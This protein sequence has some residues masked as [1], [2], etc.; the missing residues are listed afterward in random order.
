MAQDC[1]SKDNI[2]FCC[3]YHL[4]AI[5]SSTFVSAFILCH[6][7]DRCEF[8]FSQWGRLG[9]NE[10]D[11]DDNNMQPRVL[12]LALLP[13]DWELFSESCLMCEEILKRP[14]RQAVLQVMGWP[15]AGFSWILLRPS[16]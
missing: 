15:V 3:K 8:F 11:N 6:T 9:I 10:D 14:D 5:M 12:F 4:S 16:I 7:L 1:F 13:K 2:V